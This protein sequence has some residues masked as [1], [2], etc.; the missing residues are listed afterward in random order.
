MTI[1]F[2]QQSVPYNVKRYSEACDSD[3]ASSNLLRHKL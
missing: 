3:K 2:V 1:I